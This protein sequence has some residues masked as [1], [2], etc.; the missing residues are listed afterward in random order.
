MVYA[1]HMT[2]VPLILDLYCCQGCASRGYADAGFDVIGVD[3]APQPR[4]P[5]GFMQGDA[6]DVLRNLV[7]YGLMLPD[8]VHASPPCQDHSVSMQFGLADR[9]TGHLLGDTIELLRQLEQR[10]GIP[11]VVENVVSASTTALMPGAVTLC[12]SMFGLGAHDSAG[13]W[14]VLKRHR[15][16]LSSF[17]IKVPPCSC[18]GRLVGGIYGNGEQ[19]GKRGYGFAAAAAREALRAPWVT[20]DGA[21]EAIPPAYTEH[22]GRQLFPLVAPVRI[23]Q[24]GQST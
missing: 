3:V 7:R 5:Y 21:K 16:F 15:L 6:L 23:D 19:R 18:A 12:G 2:S 4:Y 10:H 13:Q 8:A 22:I 9:G 24:C 1:S 17:P 20:R 14:R 11:W